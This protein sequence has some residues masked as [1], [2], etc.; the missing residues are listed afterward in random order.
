MGD[1]DASFALVR[2]LRGCRRASE[3]PGKKRAA[4]W[5][6][7]RR[8]ARGLGMKRRASLR[9]AASSAAR[10]GPSIPGGL[11]PPRRA[12][13]VPATETFV[14]FQPRRCRDR[15]RPHPQCAGWATA[16]QPG[17]SGLIEVGASI[18]VK[19]AHRFR[20]ARPRCSSAFIQL[21]NS[22][23]VI[24]P[25]ANWERVVVHRRLPHWA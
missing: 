17:Q 6:R 15:A 4:E 12:C 9:P 8:E 13:P 23:M 18:V 25:W 14:A 5:I 7:L 10:R 22:A 21:A 3:R 16:A 19:H 20:D 24:F 1:G 2:R 11:P